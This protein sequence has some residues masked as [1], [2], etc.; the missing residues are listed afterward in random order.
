[1]AGVRSAAAGWY[2]AKTSA[3]R[4]P[5]A[6]ST[7]RTVPCACEIRAPGMNVPI[8]KPAERDDD[9][10]IEDLELAAQVRRAGGDLVGLRDRGCR[11]AG[12]SRCS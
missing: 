6:G 9:R 1:M 5:V 10:R 8:E 4:A 12:T 7:G 2:M 3:A 11:A